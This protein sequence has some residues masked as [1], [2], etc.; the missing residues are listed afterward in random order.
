M[1]LKFAGVDIDESEELISV[2][3]VEVT[4]QGQV[5]CRDGIS[6]NKGVTELYIISALCAVSQM[7]QQHFTQEVE[8]TFHQSGVVPDIGQLFFNFLQ[9]ACDPGKKVSNGLVAIAANAL[10]KGVTGFGMEF[11]R[12]Y[13]RAVLSAVMLFF[14]Q[15]VQ[16]VEAVHDCSILL[17]VITE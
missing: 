14:H 12:S 11:Y 9:F 8:V 17:L 15:Q 6:F 4:G 2:N 1:P 3:E 13:T 7:S 5:S 16:L 10:E